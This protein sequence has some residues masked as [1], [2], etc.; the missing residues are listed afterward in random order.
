MRTNMWTRIVSAAAGVTFLLA[1]GA[2][3]QETGKEDPG[4]SG[5]MESPDVIAEVAGLSCPFCAYGLEKKFVEAPGVDSVSVALEEGEVRLWLESGREMT[6]DEVRRIVRDA[7]FTPG[8]IRRPGPSRAGQPPDADG[9]R[10]T[11]GA[12]R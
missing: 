1:A 2:S 5:P 11:E 12:S 7:G 4:L 10:R 9:M 6:D 3:G 8:E